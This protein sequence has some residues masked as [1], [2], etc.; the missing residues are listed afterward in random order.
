[1][2]VEVV[3]EGESLRIEIYAEHGR[4]GRAGNQAGSGAFRGSRNPTL[5]VRQGW[6][7]QR[8]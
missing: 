4:L 3:F 5:A 6:G 2:R 8:C 1:M 7:T